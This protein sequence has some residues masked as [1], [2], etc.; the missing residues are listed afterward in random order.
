MVDMWSKTEEARLKWER[1]V[2]NTKLRKAS[3]EEVTQSLGEHSEKSGEQ[4]IKT[5]QT[6]LSSSFLGSPRSTNFQF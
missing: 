3:R 1:N 6:F 4:F 2:F 5:G